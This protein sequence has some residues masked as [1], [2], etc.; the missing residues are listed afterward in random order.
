MTNL[1]A[2]LEEHN[3]WQQEFN[4]E[5]P[6]CKSIKKNELAKQHR[7]LELELLAEKIANKIL[8]KLS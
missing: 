1:C 8:E 5:C 7:E 3:Y 2:N 4:I 6:I